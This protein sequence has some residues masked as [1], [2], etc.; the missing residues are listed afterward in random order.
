MR[1]NNLHVLKQRRRA[2]RAALTPAEARL[3]TYLRD[4]LLKGRKFRRQHSVGPYRRLLLRQRE[5][6]GRTGR[7]GARPRNDQPPG[8]FP[9]GISATTWHQRPAN[10]E[11]S[12]L[13][14]S[15]GGAGLDSAAF[16]RPLNHPVA[17]RAPPL[18]EEEGNPPRC[19]PPL[20][21]RGGAEGAGAVWGRRLL[22]HF[23]A[24]RVLPS[25]ER[26]EMPRAAARLP[27]SEFALETPGRSG[28]AS[29]RTG[30]RKAMLYF[31]KLRRD[32]RE[33]EGGALLRR[34]TALNR[35][36]GSNPSLSA[37]IQ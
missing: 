2:L 8:R 37:S 21:R 1:I 13:R 32:A 17:L 34:Y 5:A 27:R 12:G 3:W 19:S 9:G 23:V 25:S 20:K 22:N 24:L 30:E 16:L 15:G 26:R 28:I 4:G 7:C 33:A 10:R 31:V 11:S 18:L 36:E 29:S 6:R 35:I 14:G